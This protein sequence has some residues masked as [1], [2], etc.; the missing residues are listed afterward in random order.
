LPRLGSYGRLSQQDSAISTAALSPLDETITTADL[1]RDPYPIHKRAR[2][3]RRVAGRTSLA[4]AD[5]GNGTIV[6]DPG[7]WMPGML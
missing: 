1:T 6:A 3:A 5:T 2:A 7:S 4:T